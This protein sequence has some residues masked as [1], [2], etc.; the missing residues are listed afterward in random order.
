MQVSRKFFS[1]STD[2]SNDS[3]HETHACK[4]P[5]CVKQSKSNMS[6]AQIKYRL[7][8]NEEICKCVV[9]VCDNWHPCTQINW[10]KYQL[11][12]FTVAVAGL[13]GTMVTNKPSI[14]K[15]SVFL[16]RWRKLISACFSAS[17]FTI[18]DLPYPPH[19]GSPQQFS[20]EIVCIY[21]SLQLNLCM[22]DDK[23][24]R[25]PHASTVGKRTRIRW[26][27]KYE[28]IHTLFLFS[29]SIP[30]PLYLALSNNSKLIYGRNA[31][32]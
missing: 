22:D 25:K 9:C 1:N 30:L 16:P 19:F 20:F 12:S 14:L 3:F 29:L 2:K 6:R 27:P 7:K 18:N 11:D 31:Y 5:K 21:H 4:S 24:Q 32:L 15:A 26:Q 13:R 17:Y 23:I 10:L 8:R 28:R